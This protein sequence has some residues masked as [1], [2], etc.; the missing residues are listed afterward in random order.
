MTRRVALRSLAAGAGL[1]GLGAAAGCGRRT[2]GETMAGM[3][4]SASGADM[5]T[6]MELFARHSEITRQVE[7]VPGGV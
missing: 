6:Y 1:V 7:K 5:S 3:M 4:G 2:S